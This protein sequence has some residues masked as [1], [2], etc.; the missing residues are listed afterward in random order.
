MDISS[1][2]G[3]A[4]LA[5]NANNAQANDAVGIA[6]LNKALDAQV[7]SA[8]A[9]IKSVAETPQPTALPDTVGGNINVT[10]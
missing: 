3:V 1:V 10:A 2:T 4:N 7:Q 5:T 9:L 6:V 8:A